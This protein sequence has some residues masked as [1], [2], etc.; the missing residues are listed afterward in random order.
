MDTATPPTGC[1]A[2]VITTTATTGCAVQLMK[3]QMSR[4]ERDGRKNKVAGANAHF[5]TAD[6]VAITIHKAQGLSSQVYIHPS[7]VHGKL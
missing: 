2:Q 5:V 3:E 4:G 7:F 6:G 1:A